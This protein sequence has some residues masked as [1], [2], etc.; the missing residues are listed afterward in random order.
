MKGMIFAAGIGSRL[1]PFTDHHPKALVEVGGK[2]MLRRVIENMAAAGITRIV[3]NVHHFANQIIDYLADNDNFGLNIS[4]SD[5]S[6]CLLETGGG[7]LKALPLFDNNEPV[8]VHNAD[9][10]T[11]IDLKTII[12][13]HCSTRADVTLWV[14]D[15]ISSRKL[16]FDAG[17]RLKGWQNLTTHESRPEGFTAD[18]TMR[19]RGF[20]GIQV[21]SPT[22][23]D[24]L[25]KY[26]EPDAKF[27]IMPFYLANVETLDIRGCEI[28]A[29]LIDIGKPESLTEARKHN[30]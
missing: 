21:I 24:A 6:N 23:F 28:D 2:P 7:L 27:S 1:K 17:M 19:E 20:S 13:S 5:E 3:V 18:A 16:Y 22:A 11:D 29:R 8:L 9:I 14:K 12:D 4:I 10:L 26:G 25:R 30:W 15:R